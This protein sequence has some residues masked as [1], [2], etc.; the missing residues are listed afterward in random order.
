MTTWKNP[1]GIMPSEIGQTEK[2][3]YFMASL[4]CEIQNK[5]RLLETESRKWLPRAGGGGGRKRLVKGCK[6][7]AIR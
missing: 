6:F 3:K 1:E 4:I 7:S 5:V 2:D